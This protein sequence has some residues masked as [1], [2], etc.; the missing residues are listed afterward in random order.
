MI[1]PFAKCLAKSN[2]YRLKK[3]IHQFIF[4]YLIKQSD[5]ALE[6]EEQ[7][8]DKQAIISMSDAKANRKKAMKKAKRNQ[9]VV[10]EK[11]EEEV[12]EEKEEEELEEEK[13]DNDEN[14]EETNEGGETEDEEEEVLGDDD[15]EM[16]ESNLDW[17]AKDPRAGGVDAIIPQI[18][19]DYNQIADMLFQMASEKSVRSKNRKAI[20]DIVKKYVILHIG[21]V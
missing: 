16:E 19:P 12:E 18:K 4:T 6:Y 10:Q 11:E 20:Y 7:G 13:E 21:H 8:L 2:D 15:M 9:V 1:E 5:E 3:D 17:G 14:V